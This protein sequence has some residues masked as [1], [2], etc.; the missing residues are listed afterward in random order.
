MLKTYLNINVCKLN[1]WSS[2][3]QAHTSSQL[4]GIQSIQVLMSK[5]WLILAFSLSLIIPIQPTRKSSSQNIFQ[6]QPLLTASVYFYS[7]LS[8]HHLSLDTWNSCLNSLSPSFCLC[9]HLI[10]SQPYSQSNPVTTLV[11]SGRSLFKTFQ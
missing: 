5:I 4:M 6:I 8:S 9:S 2:L 10:W 11:I 3:S 7:C 1:F